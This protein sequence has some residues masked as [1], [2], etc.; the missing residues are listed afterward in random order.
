MCI[1]CG[2]YCYRKKALKEDPSW[3]MPLPRSRSGSRTTLRHLNSDGEEMDTLKKSRSYD[4]VYR[5]HEPLEGKP[6]TDFP[7]KKWDLD[8]EDITSSD[9]SEFKEPKLARDIE[10]I[11]ANN[12]PNDTETPRQM[13]RRS[14]RPTGYQAIAEEPNY[15]PPIDSPSPNSYSPTFSG[16]DRTSYQSDPQTPQGGLRPAPMAPNTSIGRPQPARNNFFGEGPS[17]PTSPIPN[18][19]VGLPTGNTKSTEV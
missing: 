11:G 1:V 8:D 9:G 12:K 19:D 2:V 14:Q 4:K 13:G 5:T 15:P 6:N 16:L 18:Q 17:Q 10:F 7:A 3:K